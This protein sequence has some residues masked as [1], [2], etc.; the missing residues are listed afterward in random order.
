MAIFKFKKTFFRKQFKRLLF[1]FFRSFLKCRLLII[2]YIEKTH[3]N[4]LIIFRITATAA[5]FQL[6]YILYTFKT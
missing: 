3:C 4:I 6:I 5:T 1:Y 2:Y